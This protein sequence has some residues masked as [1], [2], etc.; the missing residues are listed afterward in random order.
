VKKT[1]PVPQ[2]VHGISIDFYGYVWGVS[3]GAQAYRVDHEQDGPFQTFDGLVGAYTYSDMTGSRSATSRLLAGSP[4]ERLTGSC[5]ASA[6]IAI[7][8]GLQSRGSSRAR[9][10]ACA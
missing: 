6:V 10:V 5:E 9:L 7:R 3:M 1:Y 2:Y 4:R 8:P